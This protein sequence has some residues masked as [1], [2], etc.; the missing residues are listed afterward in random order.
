VV[1]DPQNPAVRPPY[2]CGAV[3][4]KRSPTRNPMKS[5][6]TTFTEM[7]VDSGKKFS[8]LD[9]CRRASRLAAP[10]TARAETAIAL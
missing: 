7:V 9:F 2:K 10:A 8:D 3:F 1:K 4:S 5:E 6:P